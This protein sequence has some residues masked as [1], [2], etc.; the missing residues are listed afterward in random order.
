MVKP[1]PVDV[2]DTASGRRSDLGS[3]VLRAAA[4]TPAKIAI[5]CDGRSLDYGA[6]VTAA[7]ACAAKLQALGLGGDRGRRMALLGAPSLD[8]AIL[9]LAAFLAGATVVPLPGLVAPD[10][11][12]RMLMDAD[13][14]IL[15]HDVDRQPD[16]V[17][18]AALMTNGSALQRVRIGADA[19]GS[20]TAWAASNLHPFSPVKIEDMWTSDLIYSSGTTGEPKGVAQSYAARCEQCDSLGGLGMNPDARVLHTVG[21]YS[22]YGFTALLASM[23]WNSTL[24]VMGKFSAATAV[25]LLQSTKINVA[26]CPPATLLRIIETAGF[27]AA[28]V[29]RTCTKISSGAPASEALKLKV[30]AEWPGPFFDVF[31]QSETGVLTVLPVHAVPRDKLSSVG[32]V[33]PT[34]SVHI[35]DE[36]GQSLPAGEAGEI[37][38]FSRT[39]MSGYYGQDVASAAATWY[40]GDGRRHIRTGDIGMLDGDGFLWLCDRKKDMINSGGFNVYPADIERVLLHHPAVFEAAVVGFP[41]LRWGESPVGFVSLRDGQ[42]AEREDLV[43]WVNERVGAIQRLA[44]VNILARLPAGTLGKVLKR[45][46]RAEYA[47]TIGTLP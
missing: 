42:T 12:A 47:E 23:W 8:F 37:V 7:T 31:G 33:L 41:S 11:H 17:A 28:V 16:I 9:S 10:A 32:K 34:V 4:T 20:L 2:A 3:R 6:L 22:M 30:A 45:Q 27:T 39:L 35:V 15:F 38:A 29:G 43:N 25:D 13:V 1:V 44:G 19:A 14:A 18:A 40:D 5:S 21:L 26:W 46:L 24:F 36:A